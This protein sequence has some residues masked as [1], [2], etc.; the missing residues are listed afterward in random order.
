MKKRSWK[1][2][3]RQETRST[4]GKYAKL[5]ACECCGRSAGADHFSDER[6]N[7]LGKGLVLC[8]RCAD[9]LVA[10]KDDVAYLAAFA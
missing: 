5:N 2:G 10:I 4:A 9:R 8:E 3:V 1:Q 6:C 7:T